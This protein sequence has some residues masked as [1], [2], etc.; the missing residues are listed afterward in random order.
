[1]NLCWTNGT[2]PQFVEL[3]REL[4]AFLAEQNGC[5]QSAFSPYNAVDESTE[6]VI[7]YDGVTPVACGALRLHDLT[8]GEIK[9]MYVRPLYRHNGLATQVLAA[10]ETRAAEMGCENLVLETNPKFTSA[11]ALYRRLGF[12]TIEP[13]GPYRT[14]CSLCLGKAIQR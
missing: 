11:V 12:Q 8:T 6:A 14:L 4:D 9:R 1:M 13:Y 2:D 3:T 10:L 5:S 7:V